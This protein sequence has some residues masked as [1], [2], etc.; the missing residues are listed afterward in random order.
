MKNLKGS[1]VAL[2][3]PF[4]ENGNV[5]YNELEKLLDYHCEN[6]DGILILGTTGESST[7]TFEEEEKIVEFSV[8]RVN[9]RVPLMVGS[10]SNETEKAV[11]MSK[12]Y[13]ELGADYLLVITPYYNKTNESGLIKHFTS[14]AEVSLCPI[15][16]YNVPSRTGMSISLHAIEVLSKHPNICGIKEASGN[17]SYSMNVAKYL[18]KDFVMLSGN[19]DTIVPMMS[20]GGAGV[21]SVLANIAPKQTSKIIDLC[22]N[23]KYEEATK[24]NLSLLDVIHNLFNEVNPIPVK[25]AMNYL[26]FNVGGYRMPL[27]EMSEDNKVKLYKSID[28]SKGMIY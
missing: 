2:V 5:N 17:I 22:L 24:I 16:M 28:K 10:G 27:D 23:S 18:S 25:A 21:I 4:D 1:I 3:T 12:K 11:K 14:V 6:S 15:V 26:G 20:I 7:L 13:S 9:K 8:K 19:D